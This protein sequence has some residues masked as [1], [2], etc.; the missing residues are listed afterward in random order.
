MF[1]H[2][3]FDFKANRLAEAPPAQ[4]GFDCSQ[5]IVGFVFL[6]VEVGVAR[7]AEEIRRAH[8]HA[9]KE[10]R[11]VVRDDVLEHD[12]LLLVAGRFERHETR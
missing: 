12:V 6:D 11:H 8:V 4:L 2:A 7:D 9:R 5:Q 10:R 1:R 3:A